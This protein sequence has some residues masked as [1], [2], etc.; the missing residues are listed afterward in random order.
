VDDRDDNGEKRKKTLAELQARWGARIVRPLRQQETHTLPTGFPALDRLLGRGGLPRGYVT[1]ISG[2]PTSGMATVALRLM[3][4][5]QQRD[6]R[7]QVGFVDLSRTFDAEYALRCGLDLERLILIHPPSLPAAFPLLQDIARSGSLTVV[8]SETPPRLFRHLDDA[9]GQITG[10]LRQTRNIL[11][12]LTTL[13]PDRP[14]TMDSYP[15]ASPLPHHAAV[16][17]LIQR[18]RWLYS[19]RDINGYRAQVLLVKSKFGR[20]GQRARLEITFDD[21]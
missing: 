1:E 13:P 20:A 11:L 2:R 5:A 18:E 19:Q 9:L 15:A 17:L 4:Q 14:A 21:R 8:V 6:R 12:F 3:A 7:Q 16:R 10:R